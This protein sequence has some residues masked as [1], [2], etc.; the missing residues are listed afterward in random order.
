MD[1]GRRGYFARRNQTYAGGAID[2]ARQWTAAVG[3]ISGA[4]SLILLVVVPAHGAANWAAGSLAVLLMLAIGLTTRAL[5]PGWDGLAV[6]QCAGLGATGLLI[7]ASG[8]TAS[9]QMP[10]LLLWN[11]L[12]AASH[13]PRRAA[14]FL[15]AAC[16]I[17][18]APLAYDTSSA[19][20]ASGLVVELV[21]WLAIAGVTNSWVVAIRRDRVERM[22]SEET[23]TTLARLDPLTGLRNRRAFDEALATLVRRSRERDM[24]L[25]MILCDLDGLK[26]I[27][28]RF[29]HLGGDDCLRT[30]SKAMRTVLR[31]DD[32]VYR[33]GGD[34]FAVLLPDCDRK[35]AVAIAERLAEAVAGH[36]HAPDGT[37]LGITYGCA[38]LGA[39][40]AADGLV[41]T[42]DLALMNRKLASRPSPGVAPEPEPA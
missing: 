34:E 37:P 16:L 19:A 25:T 21:L 6:V 32:R 24:P 15:A 18:L 5:P 33:W 10:L 8:G 11:V 20:S 38:E 41:A 31:D 22:R 3:L 35:G 12:L 42:A 1:A 23:A 36:C 14:A 7:W 4:T 28:D 29:G 27:N 39:E 9:P 2:I 40:T 30:V 26:Q 13:P 17:T